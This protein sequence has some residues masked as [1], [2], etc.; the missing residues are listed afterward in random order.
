MRRPRAHR[1][2]HPHEIRHA[3]LSG[4]QLDQLTEV[5][6]WAA[7]LPLDAWRALLFA[8]QEDL[9]ARGIVARYQGDTFSAF[10]PDGRLASL[11]IVNLAERC[12]GADVEGF[13]GLARAHFD[14]VLPSPTEPSAELSRTDFDAIAPSLI[15]HVY[16]EEMLAPARDSVIARPLC[17]GLVSAI[18]V[19]FGHGI[20]SLPRDLAAEW[21]R[22]DDELFRVALANVRRRPVQRRPFPARASSG[23]LITGADHAVTSQVH[24]LASHLG[25]HHPAGALVGL[26]SRSALLCI[27]LPSGGDA[28]SPECV[29]DAAALVRG[30][31]DALAARPRSAEGMFSPHLYWWRDGGLTALP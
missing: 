5:P 9:R 19:D 23:V 16:R 1:A 3:H 14:A 28:P 12:R 25:G 26:P 24:F 11:G 8:M 22:P 31:F 30:L 6:P 13:H 2:Q 27:P 10:L 4:L 15:A 7:F 20:G 18:A 17:A 29:A 21:N